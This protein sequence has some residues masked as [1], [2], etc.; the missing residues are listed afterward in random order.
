[1][2]VKGEVKQIKVTPVFAR[3]MEAIKSLQG[4]GTIIEYGGA[5]SS[6]SY[7]IV[8]MILHFLMT[9][10]GLR[11][12]VV[13][14]F[15]P[16]HKVSGMYQVLELLKSYG[17]YEQGI[18]NKTDHT[19]EYNGNIVLFL[20]TGEGEAGAKKVKSADFNFAWLEEADEFDWNEYIQFSLRL[21]H[22]E[23]KGIHNFMILSMN[24]VDEHCWIKTKLIDSQTPD[25]IVHH[26]TWEDNKAFLSDNYIN[27]LK[28]LINEDYN[29]YLIYT[30]GQ[31]GRIEGVIYKKWEIV[32]RLPDKWQAWQYGLDWGYV[33]ATAL[34]KVVMAED[35]TYLHECIYETSLTNSDLIERLSHLDKADIYADPS[36]KDSIEEIRR[37]GYPI[38]EANNDVKTGLDLCK[39][40]LIR[41]TKDSTNLIKEIK[42]YHY[43]K[44]RN[45]VVHE[46]PA[47]YN[48]DG[49]D[50]FRYGSVGLIQRFGYAT[51]FGRQTCVS[52]RFLPVGMK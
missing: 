31:W 22:P 41:I 30:L 10:T 25:V 16:S 15:F 24:P 34:V 52:R 21:R 28:N 49:M 18:H 17:I 27:R 3:L 11:I 38:W 45:G 48:D 19:F 20:S 44:D 35:A 6:K 37:A 43:R 36:R 26:S 5:G 51:S 39:R 8:Q 32:D 40:R 1:M 7:S 46:E 4:Q 42:S 2:V 12:A 23:I 13:R 29:H 47:K 9:E 14:K 50:A 33:H